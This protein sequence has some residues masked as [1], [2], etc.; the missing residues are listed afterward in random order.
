MLKK[1]IHKY[2]LF[3]ILCIIYFPLFKY[4]IFLNNNK[5]HTFLTSDWLINYNYGFVKRGLAGTIFY[6]LTDNPDRRCPN[7]KKARV[8]LNYKPKINIEQ[9]LE[10]YIKWYRSYYKV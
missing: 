10:N 9:R 2:W 7:I 6:N 1:T 4:Y 5:G 8:L 3:F